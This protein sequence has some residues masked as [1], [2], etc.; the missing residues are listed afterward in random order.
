MKT[1][2]EDNSIIIKNEDNDKQYISENFKS[3]RYLDITLKCL[4]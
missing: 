3:T 1:G 4:M 2:E